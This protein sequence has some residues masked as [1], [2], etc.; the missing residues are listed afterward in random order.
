MFV[1]LL[2]LLIVVP[3]LELLALIW[4][5]QATNLLTTAIIILS[6]GFIGAA[7]ARWQGFRAWSRVRADLA[8]GR[9]PTATVVDGLLILLAGLLLLTPGIISDTCGFLLLIPPVR[10][11]ARQRVIVWIRERI[12]LRVQTFGNHAGPQS[13]EVFDAEFR[14]A[15]APLLDEESEVVRRGS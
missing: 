11:L 12:K 5:I 2:I 10:R 6:T 8:A 7:L 15:D 1:R 13:G 3:A 14:R 4:L 9:P